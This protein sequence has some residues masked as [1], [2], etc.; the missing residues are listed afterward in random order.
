[1][2]LA[3]LIFLM[4]APATEGAKEPNIFMSLLP[5][6]AII[7]IFYFLF[8]RP[9]QKQQKKHQELLSSL[10]KGNRVMT[11]GGLIG[12][13]VGVSEYN[14]TLKFGENFKAEVGKS[15]IVSVLEN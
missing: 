8:I 15:Y 9:Q 5:F 10:Q 12:T 6:V 1:M 4:A 11:S 7:A 14:I 2:N 3:T 13:V